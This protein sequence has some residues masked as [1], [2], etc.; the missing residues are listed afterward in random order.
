MRKL[1]PEER[2]QLQA[3]LNEQSMKQ[4]KKEQ[5]LRKHEK[6]LR[7]RKSVGNS[8][9]PAL[10]LLPFFGQMKAAAHYGISQPA[11]V[12]KG[13]EMEGQKRKER[14]GRAPG[15]RQMKLTEE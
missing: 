5:E 7:T 11:P 8:P 12:G 3:K 13:Q 6:N 10:Q 15:M 4:A 2:E 1:T 9:R 14:T